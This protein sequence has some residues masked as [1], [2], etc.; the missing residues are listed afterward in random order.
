MEQLQSQMTEFLRGFALV[1]ADVVRTG[2]ADVARE[3]IAA[4]ELY[5]EDF[6]A[7]ADEADLAELRE[8][9]SRAEPAPRSSR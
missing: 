3:V 5:Y 8:V 2:H 9:L 4:Y 1:L 7:V 6:A